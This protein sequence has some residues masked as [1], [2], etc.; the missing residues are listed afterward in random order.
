[1]LEAIFI[2]LNLNMYTIITVHNYK[3]I[4]PQFACTDINKFECV[5]YRV[6][7]IS[8]NKTIPKARASN[9]LG[10]KN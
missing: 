2:F 5:A 6:T 10:Y 8:F 7:M 9:Y 4:E 1:M 3:I